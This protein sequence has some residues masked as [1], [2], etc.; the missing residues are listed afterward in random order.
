MRDGEAEY[1]MDIIAEYFSA[2]IALCVLFFT[3]WQ[4]FVQRRHNRISVKPFLHTHAE[5]IENN[6]GATLQVLLINSGL[7]PAFINECT[8]L[9]NGMAC[10]L[11][12]EFKLMLGRHT[13][14][15]HHTSLAK[16]TAIPRNEKVILLSVSFPE[17][18]KEEGDNFEKEI[19]EFD[20][21]IKYS[22]AYGDKFKFDSKE[23]RLTNQT[24]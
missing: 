17:I 3:A 1:L 8:V 14:R 6:S 18:S 15:V 4:T 16:D 10:D 12:K 23:N 21:V 11:E 24:N 5:R 13:A 2:I 22:S 19:D 7:G 9:R 20:V